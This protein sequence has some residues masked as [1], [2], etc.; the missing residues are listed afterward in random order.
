[1]KLAVTKRPMSSTKAGEKLKRFEEDAVMKTKIM[2]V[3]TEL[4]ETEEVYV[5]DLKSVIEGY[6]KAF[7]DPKYEVP[8][9][10]VGKK[11]MIFGNI[12]EIHDFHD[13]HFLRE[14]RTCRWVN[15]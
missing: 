1:M 3:V 11:G 7:D 15:T 4:I 13:Q 8:Q 14:L 6:Y 2:H 12:V 9:D 5:R 10:I